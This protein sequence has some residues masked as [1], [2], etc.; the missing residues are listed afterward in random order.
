MWVETPLD[1]GI[2]HPV[3][4]ESYMGGGHGGSCGTKFVEHRQRFKGS[5]YRAPKAHIIVKAS[6]IEITVG[7]IGTS[8]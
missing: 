7:N 6:R 3:E 2:T 5:S 1:E 4:S 8:R